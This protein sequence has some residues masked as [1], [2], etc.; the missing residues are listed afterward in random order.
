MI[1][2]KLLKESLLKKKIMN[3]NLEIDMLKLN[4]YCLNMNLID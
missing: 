4:E 2:S 3:N 1:N